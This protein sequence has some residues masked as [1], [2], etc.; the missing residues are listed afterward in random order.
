[1]FLV[2]N[3]MRVQRFGIEIPNLNYSTGII[4]AVCSALLAFGA[5]SL[6]SKA[7]SALVMA[8]TAEGRINAIVQADYSKMQLKASH[9]KLGLE[10]ISKLPQLKKHRKMKSVAEVAVLAALISSYPLT[11]LAMGFTIQQIVITGSSPL[12][13]ISSQSMQPTLVYGDLILMRGEKAENLDVG[14]IIAYNV[15]SPYDKVASSPTVHRIVDKWNEN[16]EIY[17]KTKGDSNSEADSWVIPAENVVGAFAQFK[18]PYIGSLVIL[19]K[20]PFGVT[21]L[22]LGFALVFLC[23]YY[24]KRRNVKND[25]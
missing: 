24:K 16:G 14:D 7:S 10:T 3:F 19:L 1:M 12:M 18:I 2:S 21:S 8:R 9:M 17:F 20:S 13:V 11:A 4:G 23:D 22:I 5:T 15:P 25:K 6:R